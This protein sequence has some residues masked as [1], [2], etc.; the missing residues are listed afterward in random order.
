MPPDDLNEEEK[1]E[2]LSE[3][4]ETPFRP[5]S[6]PAVDD[7]HPSTDNGLQ[8]EELYDSGLDVREPNAGSAVEGYDPTKDQRL[9]S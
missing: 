4:N 8:R 5:A 6:G 3:D 2:E 7:T 9:N 1:Q